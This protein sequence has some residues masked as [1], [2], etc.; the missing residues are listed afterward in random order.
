[1]TVINGAT[2][3]R[4]TPAWATEPGLL[5]NGL[6]RRYLSQYSES[7]WPEIIKLTLITGILNLQKTYPQRTLTVAELQAAVTRATTATVLEDRLPALQA[8]L[9]ELQA[10]IG[11]VAQEV[12]VRAASPP[13]PVSPGREF[14][15]PQVPSALAAVPDAVRTVAAPAQGAQYPAWWGDGSNRPPKPGARTTAEHAALACHTDSGTR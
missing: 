4:R 5:T 12:A 3:Q 1:M 13:R 10:K 6:V 15:A 14:V 9:A 8:T 2:Q 11:G 7:Q